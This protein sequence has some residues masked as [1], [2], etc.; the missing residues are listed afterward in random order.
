MR[1]AMSSYA[2]VRMSAVALL[3][4][5]CTVSTVGVASAHTTGSSWNVADGEYTVDVGYDPALFTAGEYA[6]F[7]FLLWRGPANTGEE[8]AYSHIW[9]RITNDDKDT[10]LATG[11][12]RQEIGP[13]T[14][15]F[16]FP[17]AGAYVLETSYRDA[18]G[19]DIAKAS[20]PIQVAAPSGALRLS[21]LASLV[22]AAVLGALVGALGARSARIRRT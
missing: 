1:A 15:L 17:E 10:Q 7:D 4:F 19:N 22:G 11:V 14:M 2:A 9:V 12:M 3:F 8:A 6:R 5:V 18:D 20:F 21:Q 13:T 16:A